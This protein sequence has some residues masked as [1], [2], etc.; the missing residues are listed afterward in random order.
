LGRKVLA[1]AFNAFCSWGHTLGADQP[2]HLLHLLQRLRLLGVA[3]L[4]EL[5]IEL[6]EQ[7]EH[8][9]G[10]ELGGEHQL[11]GRQQVHH[12][13]AGAIGTAVLAEVAQQLLQILEI[14]QQQTLV[15]GDAEGDREHPGPQRMALLTQ[16]IPEFHR[17]GGEGS[18]RQPQLLAPLAERRLLLT[19][20]RQAGEITLHVG[21]Q[22]GHT[23]PA[24]LFHQPLQGH[25]LAGSRGAGDQAMPVGEGRQQRTIQSPRGIAAGGRPGDQQGLEGHR[26]GSLVGRSVGVVIGLF[27][28]SD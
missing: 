27:K 6:G 23:D 4:G 7:P 5:L 8:H 9:R 21:Q 14:E 26:V 28:E 17:A 20:R 24:H 19:R 13:V 3:H 18:P 11:I 10:V 12:A 22:G 25:R 1:A 15:V 2:H 16:H